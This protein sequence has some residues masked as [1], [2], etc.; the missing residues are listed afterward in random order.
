[1]KSIV[2]KIGGH[3][4]SSTAFE[5]L[6]HEYNNIIRELI[7]KGFKAYI[8]VGGGEYARRLIS[9][10]RSLGATEAFCDEIGI[11][12]SRLNANLMVAALKDLAYPRVPQ[13]YEE[14]KDLITRPEKV[15][16]CG[17][18]QP[19]QSTTAVAALISELTSSPLIIATDV[20]GVYSSDPKLDPTAKRIEELSYQDLAQLLYHGAALAGTF[21]L[22]DQV[23]LKIIERSRIVVQVVNGGVPQNVLRA[24]L[25]MRVGSIIKPTKN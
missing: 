12:V 7:S 8:V 16:V 6:L 2:I 1:M 22:F 18:L 9:V 23:S 21:K 24:A 19:G 3:I 13:S 25:G 10:A 17:G 4:L 5:R 20:D 11:W 15:I 14:L